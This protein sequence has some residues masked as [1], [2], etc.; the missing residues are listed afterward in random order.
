MV[1]LYKWL[2][3]GMRVKRWLLLALLGLFLIVC[4][5]IVL[6]RQVF[7]TVQQLLDTLVG[8]LAGYARLVLALILVLAGLWLGAWGLQ[9]SF[10]SVIGTLMPGST[11]RVVD[12]LQTKKNLRKGPKIVVIGGGTGLSVL[13]KGLKQYTSNITAIVAVTDDGGSSG[14]LRGELGIIPPGDIRNC[15]VALA[16]RESLME[17]VLQYRFKSGEL[18]GHSLGNLF[19]AGLNDVTGG[20]DGAVQAL[21]KVLA[22][23]GQVLPAT[24]QDAAVGA[25]LADGTKVLGE[26]CVSDSKQPIKR[27]FLDPEECFPV[28]EASKAINEADAIILGPGSLY[29]SVIPNLLVRGMADNIVRSKAR[30][31]YICNVMTQP[32][33]T[34]A[35]T[36]RDH[37]QAILD[38]AGPVVDT[39]VVNDEPIPN[40]LL[41]KYRQQGS[42]PVK[43]DIKELEKLGLEVFADKLVYQTDVVRHQPEK[44]AKAIMHI[45][46]KSK[47]PAERMRYLHSYLREEAKEI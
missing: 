13:L 36:A 47:E 34:Q 4:G 9:M 45:I 24:L 27:V 14:R 11:D 15:L 28:P 29:T 21:S 3:P 38:H 16:D 12:V 5:L 2:Y 7:L 8:G 23:R 37:V 41:R 33:E 39:V 19:L 32:G 25:E 30:K 35:Y 44:L 10:G 42:I 1:R 31:I 17:E 6:D 26:C 18:A 46:I 22:I 43:N 40:R 20:F